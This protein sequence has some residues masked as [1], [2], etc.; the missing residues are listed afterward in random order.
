MT[1]CGTGWQ[2]KAI[3]VLSCWV[4]NKIV[5]RLGLDKDWYPGYHPTWTRMAQG[6]I[7]YD[8]AHGPKDFKRPWHVPQCV[9]SYTYKNICKIGKY[10]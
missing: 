10:R 9:N 6:E 2:L 4:L 1:L 8:S 7:R 5:C 3:L